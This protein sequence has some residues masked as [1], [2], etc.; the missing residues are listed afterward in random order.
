MKKVFITLAIILVLIIVTLMVIPV[1]FKSDI[2]R[3]IEEKS[4]KY[5]QAELAI[6]D[7]HLSMFKNFPNLSVSLD[8]VIISKE[9]AATRDT[10]INIPLFEASVN[11]RSLISGKE[12]IINN[13]LLRD[14]EFMPKVNAEGK[15]IGTSWFPPTRLSRKTKR[16][17]QTQPRTRIS[18][19]LSPSIISK[20]GT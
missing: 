10:L 17:S 8:N 9:E 15:R 12:I 5:I 6:G 1:F 11:L 2:L 14:C 3:L 7:V 19:R 20:S 4:S 13:I 16:L 18:T